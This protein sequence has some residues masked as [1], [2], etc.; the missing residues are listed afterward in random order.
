MPVKDIL[1]L[2]DKGPSSNT[3]GTSN[4]AG[5]MTELVRDFIDPAEFFETLKSI[6]I[7]FFTGVPDSLLKDVA[8][9]ICDN[10]SHVI[11]ANEGSA[12]AM[13]AGYHLA[14]GKVP[15]VYMQ[16]SGLGNAINPL[17]SLADPKVYGTPMLMM[18]GWRGQP[19]KKDEPQHMV[20]GARMRA[21]LDAM[22]IPYMV[23]PDYLEGEEGAAVVVQRALELAKRNLQ[24]VA[25][26]VK[27]Q[28]FRPYSPEVR[29]ASQG[30]MYREEALR[31]CIDQLGERDVVVGTTGFTS[32]E[33][34]TLREE[35]GHDHSRDFLTVG[36]MG[37]ASAI[38][39]GIALQTKDRN[40]VCFDGDGAAVMHMGNMV[41]IGSLGCKN[42]KHVVINN[43]VHDSVGGQPTFLRDVH[44]L[45]QAL[46]Y[47][48][49]LQVVEIEELR[50]AF[51][52]MLQSDGPV[53]LEVL[54]QPGA[55]K[56]LGRPKTSPAA[57][58][59]ALM[60]FLAK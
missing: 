29:P 55:R 57:N 18:L 32:R 6:G 24:P 12:I 37:H 26:L 4:G 19:G 33:V 46:G 49:A 23:L 35:M 47:K 58:K 39:Q 28:T 3:T 13:A 38:A 31:V 2:I 22:K 17:L 5:P 60:D 10:A 16:N 7:D 48:K 14:T 20:Q 44:A 30:V 59:Q 53:L 15:M 27:R 1:T 42:F 45:A 51:K 34:Y 50:A 54:T 36:S 41:T 40:V 11:T 9:Y 52:D 43:G 56:D 25:L 21:M 8:A